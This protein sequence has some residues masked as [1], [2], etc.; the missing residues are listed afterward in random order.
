MLSVSGLRC[1]Y[2]ASRVLEGVDLHVDDGEVVGLL[3]RNGMGKTSLIRCLFNLTPPQ[4]TGGRI[5]YRGA[6]IAGSASHRTARLGL[7]LVP[8]GRLVFGS[9]TVEENLTTTARARTA[10][11][12]DLAAVYDFFPRLA[13]RRRN[14]G[15]ELS[16]GEQQML[17]IGRALMTNPSL[18]VMDEASEGLAP[19]V[20]ADIRDRLRGLKEQGMSVFFAEQN[21]G[22]AQSLAD[23]IYILGEGGLIVWAGAAADFEPRSSEARRYLGA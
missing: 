21:V 23:R 14:F 9:L 6:D 10:G 15:G 20:L 1:A 5:S 2:G 16:G 7:G 18:L 19:A 8:Q 12:W 13:E 3:G 22:L 11:R 17:A 4:V